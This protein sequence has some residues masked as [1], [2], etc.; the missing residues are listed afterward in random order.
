MPLIDPANG[1]AFAEVGA[2]G[3]G[4]VEDAVVSAHRAFESGWRDLAPGK[5]AEILFAVAAKLR[6]HAGE[7][8]SLDM[9]NI[10]KP[11]ADAQDEAALG[12]RVFEYYAG[13]ISKFF[14]ET[15]PVARGGLNFTLRQPMGV[16][17]AIVPW[18]FPFPIACWKVA[19]ALAA[20]NCVVL[21][22]ASLSPL[23]ALRLGEL[24]H[25]AGLPAGVLQVV[26]GAGG[27]I[28]DALV[29]HPLV[30][31]VSFTGSTEVGS[32]IMA[33]A[34]RTIKRVSLELGGKSPNII[35]ADAD[36]D[37]AARSSPMSVFANAGQD[38]CAR[39]RVFVERPVFDRFV[40]MFVETMRTLKV[41][42]P[43]EPDTQIG[44]LVSRQ[45]RETVEGFLATAKE[46]EVIGGERIDGPGFF[47]R[48]AVVLGC[49][50]T[51][52]VW[53]EEIFGPVVCIRPFDNE[54]KMLR[55]VNDSPYGLSGSVWTNDIKRALRVV[56]RVESGVLSVNS[57]S[58]VHVEAPFGGFKQSGIGRDLGMNALEGY[59]ELKN[60]YVS[61]D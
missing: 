11:I 24:A 21:K 18:N 61:E 27:A 3:S 47:L 42:Q 53:R 48:P 45:Q 39:S 13:A 38:C 50:P 19:P 2:A 44:P 6:A 17:A 54:E 1:E 49:E 29:D 16:I 51:D 55:E 40:E 4:E 9:R 30:R 46:R 10:G 37:K 31:K 25:E 59:T 5:R 32:R 35:F 14:G 57:H 28:G 7:I 36:I 12:A 15:I 41:G 60:V 20:G 26:P 23:S 22:P 43:A 58:S 34:A 56:R 33:R 52:T 8:A